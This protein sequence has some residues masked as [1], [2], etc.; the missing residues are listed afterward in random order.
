MSNRKISIALLLWLSMSLISEAKAPMALRSFLKQHC[1]ACHNDD[2]RKSD[3][4]LASLEFN[5]K[6]DENLGIWQ[7]VLERV[8]DGEMPPKKKAQPSK[9]DVERF[10]RELERPLLEADLADTAKNGRVQSRR[11]TRVEYE[12]TLHDLLGID[13]P[14]KNLLPE[15]PTSYGFETVA[16]G[17]QLSHHQLARYLD[18]ADIALDEAFTRA[19]QGDIAFKR[20]CTP[21][22]LYDGRRQGNFRGPELRDGESISWPIG[23]QFYGRMSKT[24]IPDDGWY[25][26]TLRDVRA[27]NPGQEGAVWGTL[28]SGVC[29]SNAPMLFMIG[30]VEATEKPRDFVYEAWIQKEHI[31]EL[32][33]NDG[34][35]KRA[36]TGA[37]GGSVSY[38]GR[39]IEMEGYPGI[40]HRGIDIERIYP[41]A[42]DDGVRRNLFGDQN[43][44]EIEAD[45]AASLNKLISRF[46]D[47]VFRRPIDEAQLAPYLEIASRSLADGES[48]I[49]ALRDCYRTMLCSP[50]FLT[51]VEAPG[52][53][54]NHAVA[55]RL[56]YALWVSMPDAELL[57]LASQGTLRQP[58]TL[59]KQIER[60]L[61]DPKSDR[62]IRSFTDQW[63][64][65]NEIDFTSPDARQFREFDPVVQESM[66]LE[67]RAYV[68]ELIRKNLGVEHLVDSDFAFLNGRLARHYR[69]DATVAPGGGLQKV[70]LS[71]SPKEVRGGLITQAAILKVTADGTSTSPVVRGVFINERILG[72]PIPPPPPGVSAIEPDIRGATSI[73]DQLD[74]HRSDP[75]C[76]SCHMTIDPPGFALES[77]DPVGG[78]RTRYGI[79]EKGVKV[80]PSGNTPDGQ[81]FDDLFAWKKIYRERDEQL[82]RGFAEQFLTYA[83]G[84]PIQ[85]GDNKI[86]DE[87]VNQSKES[88]FG[89]QSLVQEAIHSSIFLGK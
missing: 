3:L 15:D 11:L 43:P 72:Q 75:S 79:D 21:E 49:D 82:A 55:A 34:E 52:E 12:H 67:T 45:P 28:R 59:T 61:A 58:D 19:L 17:Q 88:N 18:V 50:R 54:D 85:F 2:I 6:I 77:F 14:L 62:F 33:P 24:E 46:A 7:R 37:T 9:A 47:R 53:L 81:A 63:L 36:K 42:D 83:T 78:W 60:M 32:K 76:A 27:I 39:D 26:I 10:L 30:L 23:V 70:A 38:K 13:I 22:D 48:V 16:S 8:R 74:K 20:H 41:M 1:Y 56:S 69:T 40:A 86:V 4:N 29:Y 57:R 84:A 66:V 35:V 25:R 68:S 87:L 31:L 73:R 44:K 64:K 71:K 51:F 65:L 5:P 89:L 80:N